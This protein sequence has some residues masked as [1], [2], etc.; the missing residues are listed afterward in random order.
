MQLVLFE[1]FS[2]CLLLLLFE[3]PVFSEKMQL[4]TFEDTF[5]VWKSVYFFGT[6]FPLAVIIFLPLVKPTKRRSKAE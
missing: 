6:V 5:A 4:L 2:N 1:C 3:P